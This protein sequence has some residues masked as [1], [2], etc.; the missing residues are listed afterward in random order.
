M[1]TTPPSQ[2][3]RSPQPPT[4]TKSPPPTS[5]SNN[6]NYANHLTTFPTMP[7]ADPLLH[8]PR[9]NPLR[10]WRPSLRSKRN[11]GFQEREGETKGIPMAH[12]F[13]RLISRL[14]FPPAFPACFPA[15]WCGG[16]AMRVKGQR[17]CEG[18]ASF[19]GNESPLVGPCND[20]LGPRTPRGEG[21]RG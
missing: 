13:S 12:G 3:P 1:P 11:Q 9:R 7:T 2:Q 10:S 5:L 15:L 17:S 6:H 16:R 21:A 4:T 14:I 19:W 8:T 20:F 18:G